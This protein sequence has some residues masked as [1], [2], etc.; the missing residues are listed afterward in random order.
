M[1]RA[2][3]IEALTQYGYNADLLAKAPDELL[4][5]MLRVCTDMEGDDDDD[6]DDDAEMPE[7]ANDAEKT[8][9]SEKAKKMAERAKK[10]VDKY[11]GT[12]MD[13]TPAAMA[14]T[15]PA[16]GSAA[17]VAPEPT[18]KKVTTHVAYT[19][20]QLQARIDK[21]VAGALDKHV[22]GSISRLTKFQE[23]QEASQKKLTGEK[24]VEEMT[25]AGKLAPAEKD[26]TVQ[27]L[28]TLDAAQ[29]HKFAEGGKEVS[30][31]QLA[32]AQEAIRSRP[33]LFTELARTGKTSGTDAGADAEVAQVEAHYERFSESY[34]KTGQ[35]KEDLIK[36]F[37]AAPPAERQRYLR[38]FEK[39]EKTVA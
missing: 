18:P 36:A 19:E 4:A 31:T 22:S 25:A 26:R 15:P 16:G 10:Y 8:A 2:K 23:Q 27:L 11:C 7:P 24:F 13:D 28:L 39:L 38:D 6:E 14:Q 17:A 12:K 34:T 32:Q 37:K 21:A 35:K 1:D 29:V 33:S 5:E 9:L 20:E 30:R 3:M